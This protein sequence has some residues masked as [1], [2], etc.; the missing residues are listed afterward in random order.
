MGMLIPPE[1]DGAGTDNIAYI[2]GLEEIAA[3]DGACSTIM[4]VHNAVACMLIYKFGTDEQ[5]ECFL[6]PLARGEPLGVTE[7]E[8]GSDASALRT[9]AVSDDNRWGS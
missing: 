8:V 4:T 9:R 5:K 6:R 1:W 3:G 2:M 7:P